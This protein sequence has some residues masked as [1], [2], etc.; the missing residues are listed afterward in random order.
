MCVTFEAAA[1][2]F[3]YHGDG[4]TGWQ[5]GGPSLTVKPRT[6]RADPLLVQPNQRDL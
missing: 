1:D 4:A 5:C 3:G 2:M 6:G